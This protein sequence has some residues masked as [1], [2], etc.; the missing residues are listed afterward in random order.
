[1]DSSAEKRN[2]HLRA[3]A[4]DKMEFE[5]RASAAW[6]MAG[7]SIIGFPVA[8]V[9][10]GQPQDGILHLRLQ[11]AAP[12]GSVPVTSLTAGELQANGR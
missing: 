6:R 7:S 2:A 11:R 8:R 10:H 9:G 12:R 5:M 3:R 1:M 4:A